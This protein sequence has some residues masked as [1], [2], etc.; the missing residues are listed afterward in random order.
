[1]ESGEEG[2]AQ[3]EGAMKRVLLWMLVVIVVGLGALWVL[4]GRTYTLTTGTTIAAPPEKVW[5]YITDK[6]KLLLWIEGLKASTPVTTDG[7]RVGAKSVETIEKDGQIYNMDSEVLRVE[8][9]R[10]LE[11]RFVMGGAGTM[12]AT[13]ELVSDGSQTRVNLKEAV[14]SHGWFRLFAPFIGGA[15]QKTLDA[16]MAN[17]KRVVEER[18]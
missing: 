12:V 6:D 2:L 3:R 14:Q 4:G 8:A 18:Q 9:P 16:D 17:L 1:V 11:L 5:V 13:Y 15:I 7:L 10:L